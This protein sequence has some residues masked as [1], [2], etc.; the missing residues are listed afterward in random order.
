M[1]PT[2]CD[3]F[4][5]RKRKGGGF[6]FIARARFSH[7]LARSAVDTAA[8]FFS[9]QTSFP[10]S[11]SPPE[12]NAAS[13]GIDRT[14]LMEQHAPSFLVYWRFFPP[15]LSPPGTSIPFLFPHGKVE[16]ISPTQVFSPERPPFL[17]RVLAWRDWEKAGFP[18]LYF[19]LL[20]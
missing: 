15:K 4:S 10:P 2:S 14:R 17:S 13:D 6:S 9:H 1:L 20:R 18:L 7:L 5:P 16:M 19:I 12:F 3:C 11:F 8:F